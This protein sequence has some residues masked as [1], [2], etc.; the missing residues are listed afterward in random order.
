MLKLYQSTAHGEAGI[1]GSALDARAQR[2]RACAD[3]Q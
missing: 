1:L 2:L 3:A